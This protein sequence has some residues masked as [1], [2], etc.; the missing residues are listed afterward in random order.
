[1]SQAEAVSREVEKR[2]PVLDALRPQTTGRLLVMFR[3]GAYEHERKS[4]L[5]RAAGAAGLPGEMQVMAFG[6]ARASRG[7]MRATVLNRLAIAV[8]ETPAEIGG[9]ALAHASAFSDLVEVAETRPEYFF[10]ALDAI[11]DSQE[12]TW[13]LR[14]TKAYDCRFTGKGVKVAVLDTGF[15]FDHPDVRVQPTA[16]SFVD[17]SDTYDRRGHGSHCAGTIGGPR[18]RS[19]TALAYGCA[20][21]VSLYVGKVLPIPASGARPTSTR[22]SSGRS[23][24]AATSSRCRSDGRLSQ[25]RRPIRYTNASVRAR[26]KNAA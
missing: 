22:G 17:G 23:T 7:G 9:N 13:G 20:P 12:A 6:E 14:A 21:D 26:W 16:E 5:V 3:E 18:R 24:R 15:A 10:Y 25:A 8:I 19:D 1:M 2:D 11:A 4:A